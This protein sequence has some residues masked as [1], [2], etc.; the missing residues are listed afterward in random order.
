MVNNRILHMLM[1]PLCARYLCVLQSFQPVLPI[2][3]LGH[4]QT[5]S[6]CLSSSLCLVSVS[7][8]AATIIVAIY[9]WNS[10]AML[11][12]DGRSLSTDG[13][14]HT[15]SPLKSCPYINYHDIVTICSPSLIVCFVYKP[16]DVHQCSLP[17]DLGLNCETYLWGVSDSTFYDCCIKNVVFPRPIKAFCCIC[18]R[19]TLTLSHSYCVLKFIS[20]IQDD[21]FWD[22]GTGMRCKLQVRVIRDD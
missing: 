22:G 2:D 3:G 11:A 9:H 15:N 13:I 21:E 8:I 5:I 4:T 1:L 20:L 19:P 18:H 16:T 6:H 14:Q 10:S 12:R 7:V 17:I